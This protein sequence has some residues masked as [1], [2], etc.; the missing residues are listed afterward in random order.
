MVR[1][2]RGERHLERLVVCR[3]DRDLVSERGAVLL[4]LVVLDAALDPVQLIRVVARQLGRER[5]LPRVLVVLRRHRVAVRPLRARL[6]VVDHLGAV[7]VPAVGHRRHGVQ[8]VV[9]LDERIEDVQ[10]E[11]RGRRV[12]REAGI[13]VVLGPEPPLQRLVG[14]RCLRH[15]PHLRRRRLH[16]R[17]PAGRQ[18]TRAGAPT[19]SGSDST[20]AIPPYLALPGDL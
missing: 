14:S 10:D 7:D 4:T 18:R 3:L 15:R 19:T 11:L 12:R 16:S 13:E 9:Q 17:R 8:L 5:A 2:R 1:L 20:C 6:Q